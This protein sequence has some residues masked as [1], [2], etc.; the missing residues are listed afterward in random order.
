MPTL[1]TFSPTSATV[2]L[3]AL[4]HNV[5]EFRRQLSPGCNIMAIVKANAYGHGA[6]EVSRALLKQGIARVAVV[7]VDEGIALRLAGINAP[8]VLLG[9]LFPEHIEDVFAHQLTPVISDRNLIE[10]LAK[11]AAGLAGPYPIHLKVETG[12]GRLGL[13]ADDTLEL[14]TARRLPASLQLEGL[15]THLADADGETRDQTDRQLRQFNRVL[16]GLTAHG[17]RVPLIHAANSGAAVRRPDAQFSLVR[18]GIMLYGY[19]TLPASVPAPDLK[20]V[21]SLRTH[22][23]QIR[24]VP[25]GGSVS[26]NATFVAKRQTRVAILPVG[27]ADG[28]NRRLSNRGEVLVQGHRA[29]VIGLVCMDMVMIDVTDIPSA[30]V[31]DEVVIIGRQGTEEIT[32]NDVAAWLGTISYEVLCAIGPR[33]PRIYQG[34]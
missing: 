31:G 29:R 5:T 17:I 11:A 20:P 30:L 28:F 3:T 14:L 25:A 15:M 16:D 6:V 34:A 32:A 26:Y 12:M 27:Y 4:A 7:S 18:P 1:S 13:S 23:A 33:V 24:T 19:H 21:L 8:I 2:D 22:I 10:P 9:P